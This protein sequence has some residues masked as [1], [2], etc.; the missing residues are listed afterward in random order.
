M[1]QFKESL[2]KESVLGKTWLESHLCLMHGG[3]CLDQGGKLEK[4]T[5]HMN[6]RY[7]CLNRVAGRHKAY[8]RALGGELGE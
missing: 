1:E 5:R 7:Y 8:R 6:L 2:V 4:K 3:P